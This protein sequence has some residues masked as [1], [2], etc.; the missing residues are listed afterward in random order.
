M[1]SCQLRLTCLLAAL[2]LLLSGGKA[3]ADNWAH[4]RGPD[5]NGVARNASPPTQWSETKN[6]K[7]KV[8]IPGRGSG[9]PVIWKDRVF[10]V[11]GIAQSTEPQETPEENRQRS[12]R[13]GRGPGRRGSGR[14]G[15]G[16]GGALLKTS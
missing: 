16:R 8:A 7:W 6:I 3:G 1:N 9:S 12:A 4:W 15:P 13:P 10:V 14:G 5:G 11:T 2:G